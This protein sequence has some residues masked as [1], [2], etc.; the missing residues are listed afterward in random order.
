MSEARRRVRS[1]HSATVGLA[2]SWLRLMR[3]RMKVRSTN[4]RFAAA[5]G[6]SDEALLDIARN[7]PSGAITLR[8]DGE[9]VDV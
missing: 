4:Y 1:S 2:A 3:F 5:A 7:C 8:Q 6:L 9:P